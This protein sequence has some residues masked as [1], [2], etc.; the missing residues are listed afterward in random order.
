MFESRFTP[1]E[2]RRLS[3][4]FGLRYI[5]YS[6]R[7]K[8]PPETAM[9]VV[10]YRLA[11]PRSCE[12]MTALFGRSSGWISIVFN[13]TIMHLA[14]KHQRLLLWDENRL[15]LDTMRRYAAAIEATGGPNTVWGFVDGT[16]RGFSRPQA[17]GMDQRDW[18]SG[19]KKVH[20]MK[21]QGV[22]II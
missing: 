2:I 20:G 9:C 22:A 12:D 6:G 21:F 19:Y 10:L 17:K 15:T 1:G 18:W 7:V 8:C 4:N 13:E 11:R 3:H 14:R 5:R 16:I